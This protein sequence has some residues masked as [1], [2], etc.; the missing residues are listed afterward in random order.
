MKNQDQRKNAMCAQH[1]CNYTEVIGTNSVAAF[2]NGMSK[3]LA[4]ATFQI[5]NPC[6]QVSWKTHQNCGS[7][8]NPYW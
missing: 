2:T 5:Q 1:Y 3:E 8:E 7:S 4:A 6:Q